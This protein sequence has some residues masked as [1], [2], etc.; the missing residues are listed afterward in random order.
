MW[1]PERTV[2]RPA[3]RQLDHPI[4]FSVW[5]NPDDTAPTITAIPNIAFCIHC[6]TVRQSALETLEEG[7]LSAN[8]SAGQVIFIRPDAILQGIAKIEP[9]LIR[10]PEQGI[11]NAQVAAPF[12][13]RAGSVDAVEHAVCAARRRRQSPLAFT[14]LRIEPTHNAPPGST[15]ASL[16]RTAGQPGRANK[17]VGGA[18]LPGFHSAMPEPRDK[19]SVSLRLVSITQV[20]GS[21]KNQVLSVPSFN[22]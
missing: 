12:R 4:D 21:E 7:L 16:Q 18:S 22:A 13:R 14:L 8:G 1:A 11:R 3:H 19:A 20:T 17:G 10:A 15:A 5:R 6:G 9:G 2:R